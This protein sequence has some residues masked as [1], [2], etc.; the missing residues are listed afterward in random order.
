MNI[1]Q[2]SSI[3]NVL[4]V[5]TV[6]DDVLIPVDEEIAKFTVIEATDMDGEPVRIVLNR[7]DN[8]TEGT[9]LLAD[10]IRE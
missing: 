8:A 2:L 10:A 1:V 6:S 5:N 4:P 9:Y 7:G 3:N